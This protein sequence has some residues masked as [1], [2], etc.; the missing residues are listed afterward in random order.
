MSA[1]AKVGIGCGGA[2]GALV[3]LGILGAAVSGSDPATS[4]EKADRAAARCRS[5]GA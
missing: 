4:G 1:Y 2:F 3:L 5:G